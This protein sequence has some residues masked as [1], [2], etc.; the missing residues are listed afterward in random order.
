M[1]IQT[2]LRVDAFVTYA[3]IENL[4]TTRKHGTD[5]IIE[6]GVLTARASVDR[7]G[8]LERVWITAR[9]HHVKKDG[10]VGLRD[11]SLAYGSLADLPDDWQTRISA[12]LQSLADK[13][14]ISE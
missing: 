10:T 5:R 1:Q 3:D 13:V 14:T 8:M 11:A 12:D 4:R 6:W 9:G 7:D 2:N